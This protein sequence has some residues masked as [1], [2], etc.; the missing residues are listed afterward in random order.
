MPITAT[1]V[2]LLIVIAFLW[3]RTRGQIL[4]IVLFVSVFDAASALNIGSLGVAPWTFALAICLGL[5]LLRGHRP[6][7][8]IR[9]VNV[10]AGNALVLFIAY[11]LFTSFVYPFV[12]QGVPVISSHDVAPVPLSWSI[13]NFAQ[14][15]YLIAA[16]VIYLL[17]ISSSREELRSALQWYIRGCIVASCFSFYQ[18]ANAVFHI[19]YPSAVLYS[20]KSHMIYGAYMIKGMWRLNSTFSEASAMAMYMSIGL[21]LL[22]WEM[23]VRRFQLRR[24]LCF[25]L[26]LTAHLFTISSL[27]YATL[28]FLMVAGI[29]LYGLHCFRQKGLS[30]VKLIILIGL[31]CA[32]GTLVL[33]TDAGKTVNKV[34]NSVLL[35]K[36]NTESYRAR[37]AS[38][39]AALN[40]A[41][42]T[43]YM[44]AGWGSVRASGLLYILLGNVGIPG[45][46]LF[47]LSLAL[48]C[49]PL[50]E[51]RKT[52]PADQAD[53]F[54]RSLLAMFTAVLGLAIA[55]AEPVAPILWA[56][57]AIAT[58]ARQTV[59]SATLIAPAAS[60][61]TSVE[62]PHLTVPNHFPVLSE[63][64][65]RH[66]L[67]I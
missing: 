50:F 26:I 48:M 6:F 47:A 63:D 57:F 62:Y 31:L 28:G 30:S 35:D 54:E 65:P 14:A 58:A 2:P 38:N 22:G 1:T 55:G 56:L 59:D 61:T 34:V 37:T 52:V 16:V 17:A 29:S 43:Y 8:P 44:G 11:A 39:I 53:S 36:T 19:P 42:H 66:G 3:W 67:S 21:A 32:G 13:A 25:L 46:L 5:K 45:L 12:F 33:L 15:C 9:G 40:T 64:M 41:S 27:G 51:R 7:H 10:A 49:K 23:A 18:L 4:S 20:N 24:T 60:Q